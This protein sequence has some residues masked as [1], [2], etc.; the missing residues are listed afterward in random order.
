MVIGF[1][2]NHNQKSLLYQHIRN[3]IGSILKE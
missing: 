3:Q 1:F 2:H